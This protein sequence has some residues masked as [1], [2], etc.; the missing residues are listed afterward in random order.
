[1]ECPRGWILTKNDAGFDVPFFV[2]IRNSDI[3]YPSNISSKFYQAGTL[4]AGVDDGL[5]VLTPSQSYIMRVA[6]WDC[7]LSNNE[8]FEIAKAFQIAESC[9][10]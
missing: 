10:I 4:D 6:G 2:K 7:C 9:T 5:F 3:F 8:T 1:M